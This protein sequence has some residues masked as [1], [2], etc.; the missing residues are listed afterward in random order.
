M[1]FPKQKVIIQKDLIFSKIIFFYQNRIPHVLA[2]ITHLMYALQVFFMSKWF[3]RGKKGPEI[4][5]FSVTF[6]FWSQKVHAWAKTRYQLTKCSRI[7][8]C[9]HFVYKLYMRNFSVMKKKC[10]CKSDG[11]LHVVPAE[12]FLHATL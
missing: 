7:P 4:A 3:S 11:S 2:C 9:K 8:R 6:Y 12:I 10:I 5:P 1:H